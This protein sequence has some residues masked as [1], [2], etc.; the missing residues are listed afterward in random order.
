MDATRLAT[1][2]SATAAGAPVPPAP[3]VCDLA[4]PPQFSLRGLLLAMALASITFAILPALG[5]FALA[6]AFVVFVILSLW[7]VGPEHQA[8]KRW[9][10]DAS[11]GVVFPLLCFYYD[12]A[13]EGKMPTAMGMF[14]GGPIQVAVYVAVGWQIAALLSW[15]LSPWR[16][17]WLVGL[18][19]GTMAV[20]A[21]VAL[22]IGIVM[23]P[24]TF[25]GLFV[26][27][28]VLGLCPWYASF[29][30]FCNAREAFR[31][32]D[33][34]GAPNRLGVAGFVIG[35]LLAMFVPAAADIWVRRDVRQLVTAVQ[36]GNQGKVD[37]I[38]QRLLYVAPPQYLQPVRVEYNLSSDP[39]LQAQLDNI[40]RQIAGAGVAPEIDER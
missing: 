6:G 40:H 4:R 32:I 31:A 15:L 21:I 22:A 34:G 13:G 8:M 27:V 20:G 23:L 36:M 29:V 19:G 9:G 2:A 24:L 35:A 16:P 28:G 18:W 39:A 12:A 5:V 11:A 26:L 7:R 25:I 14:Y 10:V 38:T 37:A 30:Y 33:R 1:S 17:I 3:V